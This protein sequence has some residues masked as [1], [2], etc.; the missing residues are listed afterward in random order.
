M[1]TPPVP[2]AP[3][4]EVPTRH[5]IEDIAS[6]VEATGARAVVALPD[7]G[8]DAR[9]VRR[10]GW[11]LE[12]IGAEL[13]VGTPLLDVHR[14]RASL[15]N[16]GGVGVVHVRAIAR[17]SATTRIKAVVE[18][19]AAVAALVLLAPVML[20]IM[21]GVRLDSRG[22]AIFRQERVGQQGKSFTML[23][24]RTM[25][26][27]AEEVLE[28]LRRDAGSDGMLFKLAVDPR[29]TRLGSYLRRSSLDELPQLVNIALGHMA[30]VGPRPALLREV[31]QYEDDAMR[32]LAVRPGLTGLW[33]VS[34]RS[35]L[36][37]EESIRLDL[38]YVDNWSLSW[39]LALVFRTVGAV[40]HRR[41]AY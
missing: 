40:L 17:S 9:A 24:F 27:D 36:S 33:Q 2:G 12:S 10:V 15:D 37:W 6:V 4:F 11:A 21:F 22:P 18:R 29:V 20:T 25:S 32:R 16:L 13:Y 26:T 39:D 35:D 5:G 38:L 41:G 8:L 34:G 3:G 31:Q 1:T 14:S 28:T 19:T 23:K 7:A 30:L